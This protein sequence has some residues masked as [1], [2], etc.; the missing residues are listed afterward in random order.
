MYRPA[1]GPPQ[2]LEQCISIE[3]IQLLLKWAWPVFLAV[4]TLTSTRILTG[5]LKHLRHFPKHHVKLYSKW[6]QKICVTNWSNIKS[7]KYQTA[8]PVTGAWQVPSRSKHNEELGWETLPERRWCRRIPQI[9][10]IGFMKS[11]A[12]FQDTLT[13]S[14]AITSWNNVIIHFDN[15]PYIIILKDHIVS[16]IRPKGK[17]IFGIYDPFG[18][19]YLAQLRVAKFLKMSQKMS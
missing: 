1:I 6:N 2:S 8:L 19:R 3:Q 9:I 15:I 10:I 13:V 17:H 11:D 14:N 5:K 16:L 7:W 4:G 12:V 18:I